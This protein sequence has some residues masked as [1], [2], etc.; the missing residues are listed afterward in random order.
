[1]KFF[2]I[3]RRKRPITRSS[4]NDESLTHYEKEFIMEHLKCPD[5]ETG[6][7]LEGPRGG[8]STNVLCNNAECGS[9]FNLA[10]PFFADRISDKAP[11]AQ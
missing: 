7:L 11:Q 9:K 6:G 2:N 3:F 1:M 4:S 8:G 5:C 10:L